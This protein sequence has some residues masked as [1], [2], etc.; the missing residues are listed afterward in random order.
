MYEGVLR[1]ASHPYA[2]VAMIGLSY[3]RTFVLVYSHYYNSAETDSD[4]C[5]EQRCWKFEKE[6]CFEKSLGENEL[7]GSGKEE[8][9]MI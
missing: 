7:M 1:S 3:I 5:R 8:Q 6:K 2:S 9:I 4:F